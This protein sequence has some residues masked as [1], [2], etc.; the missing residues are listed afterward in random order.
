MKYT[1]SL[2]RKPIATLLTLTL[3]A[4]GAIWLSKFETT[5]YAETQSNSQIG[6]TALPCYITS[7]A[8]TNATNCKTSGGTFFGARAVNTTA[9]LYYLRMYNLAAAPTCS[10]ATGFIETI[11]IP[12]STAGAGIQAIA[13]PGYAY[14][15]GIGF[16]LTGGGA[17]NDNTNAAT[18]VFLTLLYQ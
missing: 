15:A 4:G 8:S 2:F 12:A 9:T 1:R 13:L 3:F 11:P 10:S 5:A 16:C 6:S 17:N 18:G 14:S 7:A